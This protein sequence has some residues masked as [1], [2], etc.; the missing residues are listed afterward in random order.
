MLPPGVSSVPLLGL[1]SISWVLRLARAGR[2]PILSDPPLV[3]SPPVGQA[4]SKAS[5]IKSSSN[6]LPPP[7]TPALLE[8]PLDLLLTVIHEGQ[9]VL[10]S[11]CWS[12]MGAGLPLL[13]AVDSPEPDS[14]A[15]YPGEKFPW[16][17]QH[18]HCHP[19]SSLRG[20]GV[21]YSSF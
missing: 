16:W 8:H 6:P 15:E 20:T 9:P 18:A 19:L 10:C 11:S 12:Q 13:R 2:V 21:V 4:R 1:Q 5:S 17:C 3:F 14:A 7:A